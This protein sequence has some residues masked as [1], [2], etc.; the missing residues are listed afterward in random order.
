MVDLSQNY[1]HVPP[2][3]ELLGIAITLQPQ[4]DFY[5]RPQYAT[6]L[7]GWFLDRVR[8]TNPTLSQQL[9][10]GQE[11]KPF[12]I[13]GFAGDI[14]TID[15]QLLLSKNRSYQ[16][17]ITALSIPL[18][19]WC[20][21]W[22]AAPPTTLRLN[23]TTC[24][25]TDWQLVLPPTTYT[26]IW[27]Q[28]AT[29]N[30]PLE[31]TFTS[32]TSF[33]KRK[34]HMP[35][36]IPENIFQSYLR[37]WNYFSPQPFDQDEFL[38][39]VN[40]CIVILRHDIRSSKVQ[41]G[42]IGSVTGFIGSIQLGLTT[43]AQ[44]HLEYSQLARALVA[45]APYFQTGHKVTFGLGQTR[46]GWSEAFGSPIGIT[47]GHKITDKTAIVA[48]RAELIIVREQELEPIFLDLKIRQGGQRASKSAKLWAQ[49]IARQ[50]MGDSL[51]S[52][53]ADLKMPYDTVKKYAQ[54]AK[55][56]LMSSI[57][58]ET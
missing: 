48:A 31:L 10:D 21:E 54:L 13:S 8:S 11:E 1:P 16:W 43:Q 6:A 34:N 49:I 22:L 7:H 37:R 5:L 30:R 39:W 19:D 9:H 17:Q 42:K 55:K 51:R 57:S 50:E 47:S 45:C 27:Q 56:N 38:D 36:P 2:Q 40:D 29:D 32:P 41:A 28:A 25:I 4:S 53:A 24:R 46:L 14:P 20:R 52:I 3:T 35:L 33:R 26:K 18:C 12:T 15:R 58:A 23:S 44:R